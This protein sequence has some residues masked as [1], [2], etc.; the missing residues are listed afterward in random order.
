M[1]GLVLSKFQ[2][3]VSDLLVRHRSILDSLSKYQESCAKVNRSIMKATTSC[4][5]ININAKKQTIPNNISYNELKDFMD[6]HISGTLC[7]IC[8]DKVEK[9]IGNHVFYLASICN[10]LNLNLSTILDTQCKQMDTL[11]KYNLY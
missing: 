7:P 2:N 6:N 11:G 10:S 9:E 8:K 5:C 3:R 1:E 4:G